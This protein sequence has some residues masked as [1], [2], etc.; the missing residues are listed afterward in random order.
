MKVFVPTAFSPNGDNINDLFRV[1][2]PGVDKLFFLKVYNRWGQEVFTTNNLSAGW[3]G[4]FNSKNQPGGS[5][6]WILRGKDIFGNIIN[7][8]GSVLLIR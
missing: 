7:Q 6:I 4:T 5:Y 3:D 2:A 8:S 1:K